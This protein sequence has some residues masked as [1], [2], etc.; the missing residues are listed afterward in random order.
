V[1]EGSASEPVAGDPPECPAA[2][3]SLLASTVCRVLRA[4]EYGL[5]PAPGRRPARPDGESYTLLVGTGGRARAA[6]GEE[7][8]PLSPG[9]V[10]LVPPRVPFGA[11]EPGAR[12]ARVIEV[13]FSARLHGLL[14]MPALY[15]LP[16]LHLPTRAS[17]E[18]IAQAARRIV[19]D[20]G[21]ARPGY[22]M[23]LNAHCL[24]ILSFLWRDIVERGE[25]AARSGGEGP[26]RAADVA[27]LAPVL[28]LI[29]DRCAEPLTLKQLADLVPLNPT[30]FATWFRHVTG[31]SPH[32]Y[33]ARYRVLGAQALL[34]ATHLTL[35]QVAEATGHANRS[36]LTRAFRRLLGT[37]PTQLRRGR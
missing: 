17:M 7:T 2:R 34:L 3:D 32:G 8:Y 15:G 12:R 25:G 27:R 18:K 30:Y 29:E 36:H 33:L 19:Y 26:A 14:D 5:L 20:L 4:A 35:D 31:V 24:F 13:Q 21:R 10:L 11:A 37:T 16:V 22:E 6:V 28:R 9:V 23:A 1:P